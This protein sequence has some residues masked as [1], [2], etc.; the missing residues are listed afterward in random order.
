MRPDAGRHGRPHS[1]SSRRSA[2]PSAPIRPQYRT[3]LHQ[4]RDLAVDPRGLAHHLHRCRVAVVGVKKVALTFR[5]AIDLDEE[6]FERAE[7]L[8]VEVLC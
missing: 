8:H 4:S 7:N 1:V 3:A 2:R 6:F 5:L